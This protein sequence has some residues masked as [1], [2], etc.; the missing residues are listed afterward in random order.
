MMIPGI[1]RVALATLVCG[2]VLSVSACKKDNAAVNDTLSSGGAVAPPATPAAT[3]TVADVDIGKAVG[4]DKKITDKTDE[5]APKDQVYASVHTTGTAPST[6][7]TARW[8]FENGSV[9]DERSE[10][11]AAN[12]DAYTE[13]HI[14]KPT[15]F[16]KGKYTLHV[17][18]DGR[19]V[20]TK[21]F[22]VK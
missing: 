14:A 18:L 20:Q 17:L 3:V 16:P 21:D 13:F 19:E 9:V 11:V 4:A 10:N 7:I 2:A 5:F 8:T 12:G 6:S 15:G 1:G 22:T